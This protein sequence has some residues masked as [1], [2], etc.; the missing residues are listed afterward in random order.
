MRY[1]NNDETIKRNYLHKYL[2]LITQ[3]EAIKSKSHPRFRF[4]GDF[5]KFFDIDHRS[6]LKYYHRYKQSGRPEDLLPQKRGP[7][8]KS[9]RPIPFI[10][11]K[12]VVLRKNGLNRYEI[13]HIL[14][15]QL[16]RNT[17]SPSGVY[18]ILKRHGVNR[19]RPPMKENK[20]R[21]IKEKAGELAH[22]DTHYLSKSLIIKESQKLYLVC[23]VDSCTRIAW[24]EL[25]HDIKALTVMF[26]TLKCLNVIADQFDIRFAE[27]LTDNGPE[28]GPK[29]S[30][31]KYGHPFERMLIEMG[32]KHRYTR[33]YRPQTNGK[34]ER[35]WRTIEDDLFY[36][37]SFESVEQIKDELLQY[38]VYYNHERPHQGINGK[39]PTEVAKK[40]PRIT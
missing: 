3:Y 2:Y 12:V 26:A 20:R 8:W 22:I 36:E 14:K 38:L 33:P 25:V 24:A 31:K 11:N 7:K 6:F 19:L 23:V 21:I 4:V 18:N 10:E 39:T 32:I 13:V 27:V 15:P 29:G 35:F 9:R 34:A 30:S 1:K 28:F 37:T 16:K 5:Y 40:S 17:P